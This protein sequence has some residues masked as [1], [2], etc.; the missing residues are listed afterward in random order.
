MFKK[1]A[2]NFLKRIDGYLLANHP[3]LWISKLHYILWYGLLLY[4]FSYLLGLAMPINLTSTTDAGLWY[5]LLTILSF[6]LSW[7]WGY[8]YLIFNREKNYGDLKITDE[9]KNFTLVFLCVLI[10][11]CVAFPFVTSNNQKLANM[12]TNEE[13]IEDINTLNKLEPYIPTS[14]YSYENSYDTAK[15]VTFFNVRKFNNYASY[16][17]YY[18]LADS[19]RFN[20]DERYKNKG[21]EY[22]PCKNIEEL[23]QKMLQHIDICKK[24]TITSS[25]EINQLA[26]AYLNAY[27]IGW[28]NTQTFNFGNDY[29]KEEV[30]IAFRNIYQAKFEPLFIWRSEFLWSIFY[31]SITL[32]LMLVLFKLNNWRQFLVTAIILALYPLMAFIIT[33]IM[34]Y[35]NRDVA[36]QWFVFVLFLAATI[37][38]FL[39][40]KQKHQ[41][42]PIY[43]IFNQIFFLLL[44]FMPMLIV[45]YLYRNTDTFMHNRYYLY[46]YAS[47]VVPEKAIIDTVING[48]P[49]IV[50]SWQYYY[51]QWLRDYWEKE[52]QKWFKIAKYGAILILVIAL[53]L[54]KKLFVKQ[55][56]LPRKN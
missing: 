43:N 46:D 11:M 52:Y 27:E 20:T 50:Y 18:M 10:F 37:S 9:Y 53:P 48:K 51:E 33:Q 54:M 32:C 13:L 38:L 26:Q 21:I 24:Y 29:Y 35:S 39:G 28:V 12:Y 45:Y 8:R 19:V 42:V 34:N 30:R 14:F 15:K 7:F 49:I 44:L 22:T 31:V 25:I 5:V 2:P 1:I 16:T 56:A 4:L 17:P 3:I 47:G 40:A 36:F 23:K 41:F 55:M 6:I